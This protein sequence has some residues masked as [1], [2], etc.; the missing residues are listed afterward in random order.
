ML[1]LTNLA[2]FLSGL[3]GVLLGAGIIALWLNHTLH[4]YTALKH[5]VEDD[6]AKGVSALREQLADLQQREV[7]LDRRLRTTERQVEPVNIPLVN[8]QLKSLGR[9]VLDLEGKLEVVLDRTT[10]Q[11]ERLT[12]LRGHL[13]ALSRYLHQPDHEDPAHG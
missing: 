5:R 9:Q 10:R 3:G 4:E 8:Q 7:D 1:P 2:A 12:A 6:L 13:A 11:D